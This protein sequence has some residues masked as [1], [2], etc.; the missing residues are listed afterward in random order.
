MKGFVNKRQF[1]VLVSN[2]ITCLV[3]CLAIMTDLEPTNLK[4]NQAD[5][6]KMRV[7]VDKGMVNS[8]VTIMSISLTNDG[9]NDKHN[10]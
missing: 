3:L 8:L 7:K 4:I 10:Q 2:M 6:R 1:T 9:Y 5:M